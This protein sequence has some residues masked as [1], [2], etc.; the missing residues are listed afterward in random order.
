MGTKM[1]PSHACLFM[2]HFEQKLLQHC[3]LVPEM[4]K[5]CIDNGTGATSMSHSQLL[6][7]TEFVQNFHPPIKFTYEISEQSVAFSDMDIS[8][9]QGKLTTSV[10][11]KATDSGSYLDHRS[12]HNPSTKNSIAS[13]RFQRL[14]RLC[15]DDTDFEEKAGGGANISSSSGSHSKQKHISLFSLP[16]HPHPP[17]PLSL[18]RSVMFI[19]TG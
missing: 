15:S 14:R 16:P 13:S 18:S 12:S 3:K 17:P 19:S 7:F 11:Y 8:L 10:Y 9:K 4:Y 1:G 5:R 6:D 2:G